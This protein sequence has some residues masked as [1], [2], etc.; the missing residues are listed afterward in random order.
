MRLYSLPL[1]KKLLLADFRPGKRPGAPGHRNIWGGGGGGPGAE[2]VN[3][4]DLICLELYFELE[5]PQVYT[6]LGL[7]TRLKVGV[8]WMRMKICLR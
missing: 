4:N 3:V 2:R 6:L 8:T 7:I 5:N 1:P